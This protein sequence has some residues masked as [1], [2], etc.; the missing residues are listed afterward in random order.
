MTVALAVFAVLFTKCI[1]IPTYIRHADD[2]LHE[3]LLEQAETDSM[4]ESLCRALLLSISDGPNQERAA[5]RATS[6]T[7]EADDVLG[8]LLISEA[9]HTFRS[10]LGELTHDAASLWCRAQYSM[11]R[12]EADLEAIGLRDWRDLS[13]ASSP[14]NRTLSDTAAAMDPSQDEVALALFPS[15]FV[16]CGIGWEIIFPGI[17]LRSSLSG[18]GGIARQGWGG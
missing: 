5:A 8:P 12:C 17:V 3:P 16:V 1:F 13:L 7:K 10:E 2:E 4:S 6:V 15:V 18:S 9:R 14:Y 11:V